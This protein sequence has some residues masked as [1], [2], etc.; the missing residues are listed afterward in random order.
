MSEYHQGECTAKHDALKEQLDKIEGTS[1]ETTKLFT[2]IR[3]ELQSVVE[4]TKS[5]HHRI[6][7]QGELIATIRDAVYEMKEMRKEMNDM[8][9][10]VKSLK[11]VPNKRWDT[12]VSTILNTTVA[13]IIGIAI[14]YVINNK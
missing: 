12:V 6:T 2:E 9:T 14:G 5:A 3:L 7:E 10:D 1:N 4:S 8:Q 11:D 13:A